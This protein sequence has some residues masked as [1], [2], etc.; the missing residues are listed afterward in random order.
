MSRF[1]KIRRKRGLFIFVFNLLQGNTCEQSYLK[2]MKESSV[3]GGHNSKEVKLKSGV[4][5]LTRIGPLVFVTLVN[6]SATD[7]DLTTFKYVDD[8]T[9][10][11]TTLHD[12]PPVIQD[13]LDKFR[14][15]G[16][17]S[18]MKLNPSKCS[19]MRVSFLRNANDDQPLTID[20]V[21]FLEV[22]TEKILVVHVSSDL[23]WSNNISEVLKKANSQLYLLNLLKCFS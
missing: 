13:H 15:W 5:Q 17:N 19:H 7:D 23:T 22:S 11:A 21:P 9:L 2:T 20:Q 12:T 4:P 6:D 3:S 10:I 14:I 1:L 16:K 18:H 8:L